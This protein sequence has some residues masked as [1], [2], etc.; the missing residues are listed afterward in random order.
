MNTEQRAAFA[1]HMLCKLEGRCGSV[2]LCLRETPAG[3]DI[4]VYGRSQVCVKDL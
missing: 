1:I 4:S 2:G 3:T